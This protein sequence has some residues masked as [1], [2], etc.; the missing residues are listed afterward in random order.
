MFSSE[1]ILLKDYDRKDSVGE[2]SLVVC[3]KG[4]GTKKN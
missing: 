2:E 3:L 4:L 1:R